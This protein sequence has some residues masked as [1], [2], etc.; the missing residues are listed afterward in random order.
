[1]TQI[2]RESGTF[3]CKARVSSP[4]T[5]PPR[6]GGCSTILNL[7][8]PPWLLEIPF[9]SS[10]SPTPLPSLLLCPH[11]VSWSAQFHTPAFDCVAL[12]DSAL[13]IRSVMEIS[14]W[15]LAFWIFLC[16]F[17]SGSSSIEN[18]RQA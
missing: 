13:C 17:A 4:P 3:H 1:M 9:F 11:I 6:K 15:V 18:F 2:H 16:L 14:Y 5:K 12:V 10:M 7:H 8:Q